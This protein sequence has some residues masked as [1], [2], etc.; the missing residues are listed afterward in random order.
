M[1]KTNLTNF[2]ILSLLF[3][4]VSVSAQNKPQAVKFDEFAITNFDFYFS[5]DQI[6]VAQRAERFAKQMRKQAGA[7]AYIIYYQARI[8]ENNN[9]QIQYLAERIKRDVSNER[10]AYDDVVIVDGGFRRN[11][12]FEFWI[13][14]KTAAPPA[15]TPSFAESE[16]FVCPNVIVDGENLRGQSETIVFSVR[17]YLV[18][19]VKNYTLK[20]KISGGE[21]VEGQGTDTVKVKLNDLAKKKATAFLEIEDLPLPCRKNFTATAQVE[22]GNLIL[23]DGFGQ[24]PNGETRARLDYFLSELQKNPAAKGYVIVYG[25]RTSGARSVESRIKLFKNHFM[26]R[27][28]GSA[29][30]NIVRGGYREEAFSEMWLSFGEEKPVPTPTVDAKFVEVPKPARKSRPRRK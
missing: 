16:T 20:W 3:A 18:K 19:D 6:T 2:L 12:E 5:Y 15:P 24:V 10:L 26:F 23:L 30:I 28:F 11:A 14:P 17:S 7:K 13:A 8:T 1:R 4:V 21:I 29:P 27:G 9:S 22:S 25:N